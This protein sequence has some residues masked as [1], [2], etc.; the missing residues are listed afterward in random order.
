MIVCGCMWVCERKNRWGGEYDC[1][2]LDKLVIVVHGTLCALL[3]FSFGQNRIHT[4]YMTVY[5]VISLP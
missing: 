2:C 3:I 1:V 5:L 4:P